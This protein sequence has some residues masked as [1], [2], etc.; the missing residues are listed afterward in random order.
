MRCCPLPSLLTEGRRGGACGAEGFR[1]ER[2]GRT[3]RLVVG[4][5][6][7]VARGSS[8]VYAGGDWGDGARARA[9][10]TGARGVTGVWGLLSDDE[11]GDA[12]P[13]PAPWGP[14]GP[15]SWTDAVSIL[16]SGGGGGSQDE[17]RSRPGG[18][19][20]GSG[21]GVRCAVGEVGEVGEAGDAGVA[22]SEE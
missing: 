22:A 9:G 11:R 16:E 15:S 2:L 4:G 5:E 21:G 19:R 20:G 12:E 10:A 8:V 14:R 13:E 18:G 3:F 1:S 17:A 7:V 6:R